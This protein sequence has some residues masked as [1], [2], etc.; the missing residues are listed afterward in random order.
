[1]S[2]LITTTTQATLPIQLSILEDAPK[3]DPNDKA[4]PATKFLVKPI[5]MIIVCALLATAVCLVGYATYE[6]RKYRMQYKRR[7]RR[8]R[9][10]R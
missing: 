10:L 5:G 9:L 3:F 8:M 2:N 1:M 7:V 6:R 4:I